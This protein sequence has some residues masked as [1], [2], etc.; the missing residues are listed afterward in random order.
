MTARYRAVAHFARSRQGHLSTASRCAC[1]DT[2]RCGGVAPGERRGAGKKTMLGSYGRTI[3]PVPGGHRVSVSWEGGSLATKADAE[4]AE[5]GALRQPRCTTQPREV[6]AV[7]PGNL[8]TGAA[9]SRCCVPAGGDVGVLFVDEGR[10]T[11]WV[12]CGGVVVG[13]GRWAHGSSGGGIVAGWGGCHG[14]AESG[15]PGGAACAGG[16]GSCWM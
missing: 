9:V 1:C 13:R 2:W 16:G 8:A 3:C 5:A 7:Q 14:A 12:G 11:T 15:V 4:A 10:V 6:A